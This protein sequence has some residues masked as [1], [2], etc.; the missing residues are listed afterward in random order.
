MKMIVSLLAVLLLSVS[1]SA[2]ETRL[3]KFSIHEKPYRFSNYFEFQ[4]DEGPCGL[5]VK[6]RYAYLKVRT[7]YEVYDAKGQWQATGIARLL[8]LG[9][10]YSWGTEIDVYDTTGKKIGFIDGQLV[11]LAAARFSLYE[12]DDKGRSTLKAIAYMDKEKG[13]FS[14]VDPNND[15]YLFSSLQRIFLPNVHDYWKGQIFV[16]EAVNDSVMKVF[17]AF[18]VDH[19]EYFRP[20]L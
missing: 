8:T 15:K 7:H 5:V 14:I 1:G 19:Q 11:T 10:L 13:S 18:A 3:Q 20:D 16:P 12:Y 17:A 2:A 4:G 6:K 9:A